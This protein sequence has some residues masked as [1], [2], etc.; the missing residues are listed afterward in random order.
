M[1]QKNE[2]I[3]LARRVSNEI[4]FRL[5]SNHDADMSHDQD[6]GSIDTRLMTAD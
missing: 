6:D 4:E 2:S 5:M 1:C 3:R